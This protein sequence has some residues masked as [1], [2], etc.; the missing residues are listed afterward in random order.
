MIEEGSDRESLIE[1][2]KA[3]T[4]LTHCIHLADKK[5]QGFVWYNGVLCRNITDEIRGETK[6]IV[7][8]MSMR[9]NLL[10][11]AHDKTR[12]SRQRTL[13]VGTLVSALLSLATSKKA[14]RVVQWS[15]EMED[16]FHVL[17]SKLC[18]ASELCI[19]MSSDK[20]T[21]YTD[22]PRRGI[23]AVLSVEKSGIETRTAYY[24]RQLKG[25]EMRYSVTEWEALA[26]IAVITHFMPLLLWLSLCGCY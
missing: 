3:D 12:N 16:A 13:K 14:P 23:R 22:A 11:I 2:Q 7:V 24:S 19:P 9:N 5:E 26:V 6:L 21:L 15:P 25:A 18:N 17:I 8:P 20:F 4:S 1:S 10:E